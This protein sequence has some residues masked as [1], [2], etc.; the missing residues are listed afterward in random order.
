MVKMI[1]EI[2]LSYQVR[3][4]VMHNFWYQLECI[5]YNRMELPFEDKTIGLY[6]NSVNDNKSLS[7]LSLLF[8]SL[9]YVE[10]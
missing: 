6:D 3:P 4:S 9:D 7:S 5:A 1:D 10:K 8:S 2:T